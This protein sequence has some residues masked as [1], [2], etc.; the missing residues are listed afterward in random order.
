MK[1]S[2]NYTTKYY[3]KS[4]WSSGT[5]SYFYVIILLNYFLGYLYETIPQVQTRYCETTVI[6]GSAWFSGSKLTRISGIVEKHTIFRI[7]QI[8]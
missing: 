4:R 3:D 8:T 7:K 6:V 2:L 1:F 5:Y